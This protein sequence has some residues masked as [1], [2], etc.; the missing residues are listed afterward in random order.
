[1]KRRKGWLLLALATWVVRASCGGTECRFF[2][3]ECLDGE[4]PEATDSLS[5]P[6]WS[7]VLP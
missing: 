5:P 2:R 7:A 1:M 6:A 4:A 3:I